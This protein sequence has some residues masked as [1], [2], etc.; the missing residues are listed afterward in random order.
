MG[1][2]ACNPSHRLAAL[3]MGIN[4]WLPLEDTKLNANENRNPPVKPQNGQSLWGMGYFG[5][6]HR[7]QTAVQVLK[8]GPVGL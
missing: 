3:A 1:G 4:Q 5:I 8:V 7:G 6:D 2:V